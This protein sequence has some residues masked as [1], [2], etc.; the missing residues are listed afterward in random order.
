MKTHILNSK[1]TV[2]KSGPEAFSSLDGLLNILDQLLDLGVCGKAV[3]KI[4]PRPRFQ[5]SASAVGV[6]SFTVNLAVRGLEK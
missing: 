4:A 3:V 2:W 1:L 5:R 6:T